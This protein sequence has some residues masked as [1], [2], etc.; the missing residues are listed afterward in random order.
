M[1]TLNNKGQHKIAI[2]GTGSLFPGALNTKDFWLN[3]LAEKDFIKDVPETHWLKEDYFDPNDKSGDKIYCKKGAFLDHIS[4][5]PVEFGMPPNMLTTTDTV[6]LLSLIVVRDTL[7]DTTSYQDGKMD[8]NKISVILGVAGGTELIGQMS[9]RIHTPEWVFAMR[10]QGLPETKI[11]AIIEDQGKCYTKW[12]ENTF[13]GLLG[14]VVSGRI[15]NRFDLKGTN[16]VLDAACASSLAAVK[17]AVQELQLGTT[18][19]VITGGADALNDIFMFMCFS[20]T[21]ALSPSED[22]KPF[23]DAG[24]G[25]VLGEAIAMMTLKRLEDAERDGDKIYAVISSI[26]SSSDGKSGSI[27][28][29]DSNGQ[30]I[31]ISRAYEYAGI[32]TGEVELIEAHGTGTMAGD[33]AEFNGLRLAFGAD[34]RQQHC[35]LGSVKSMI[36][37]TKSAAGAASMLK[38]VMALNNSILPPT[39]KV[40]KPNPKL[41]LEDSPFYL[42]TKA[43]PWIHKE[44]TTLKAGVSS[45]GFGGTNF[46]VVMESYDKKE[47]RPKR[48]YMK[49]LELVLFSA[50]SKSDLIEKITKV[51]TSE[52]ET[53]LVQLAKTAQAEFDPTNSCRLAVLGTSTIDIFKK[54]RRHN[55]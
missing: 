12:N 55:I 25:T 6:Q 27:Y 31:A 21:T 41:H 16:C 30:S 34:G 22:C 50:N 51:L 29:P 45:M 3:I 13:P 10:K 52:K 19:M 33:Y 11:Q 15:A 28:A 40:K 24:D 7:A 44:T 26:G 47:R 4:F 5:D 48:L 17:M 49:G 37:H 23:S 54:N 8:K 43:R 1:K 35:A 2:V 20:K 32:S 46:H 42:N 18:D 9:A 53:D 36:G 39:L 14:N 38:V